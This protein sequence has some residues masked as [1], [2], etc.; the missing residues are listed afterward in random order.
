MVYGELL[1]CSANEDLYRPS[2]THN[3][4]NWQTSEFQTNSRLSGKFK[5]SEIVLENF[6]QL[7]AKKFQTNSRILEFVWNFPDSLEFVWNFPDSLQF[8]WIFFLQFSGIFLE[9]DAGYLKIVVPR[10]TPA[11]VRDNND[12]EVLT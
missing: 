3:P 1:P 5:N 4:R 2:F 7:Q 8:V 10:A 11:I 12:I 6:G 9:V